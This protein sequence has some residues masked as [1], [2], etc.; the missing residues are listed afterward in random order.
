MKN[1]RFILQPYKGRATRH[2][3]PS[4]HRPQC[5]THYIDTEGIITFPNYVGRCNRE[6]NCGYHYTPKQYFHD[7]PE[8]KEDLFKNVE[9]A[10]VPIVTHHE[11][12]KTE[13]YFFEA[14]LMLAT[15]KAYERNPLYMFLAK[16]IGKEKTREQMRAYHTGTTKNGGIA[17]WLVDINGN[18]RDCKI[19]YYDADTGHRLKDEH[20]H[21]TWLHSLMRIDKERIVACF[22]GE[23]LLSLEENKSKA[24]AIVESEKSAIV[25]SIFI[26]QF[27]WI[28]TGGKDGVFNKA[29]LNVL[30]EHKVIL[31]PDLGMYDNWQQKAIIL[32]HHGIDTT[33]YDFIEK[34]ASETDRE[35]GLDIADFLLQTE[36]NTETVHVHSDKGNEQQKPKDKSEAK[37]QRK[38]ECHACMYSHEGINGTYCDKQKRYV[39]YVIG[40][41]RKDG[42]PP[43]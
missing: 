1:N 42:S 8:Q 23:H 4:C 27:V 39:E 13:P 19:M 18:I 17:Y 16:V 41:C 7:F 9:S 24:I 32:I 10:K 30:R 38:K 12:L 29:D 20:H 15:E 14:N 11:K 21:P 26:P 2:E 22:F 25:A 3:C 33:V 35:A 5:F 31:F 37:Q 36:T 6:H 28:A 43:L 34:N 40:D